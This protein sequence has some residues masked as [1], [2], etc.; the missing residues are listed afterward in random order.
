MTDI[1]NW[2][3]VTNWTG[4]LQVANTNSDGWFWVLILYGVFFVALLLMSAW[5]FEVALLTASFIGFVFGMFLAYIGLVGWAWVLVFV[6]L[7][8]IMI[9]YVVWTQDRS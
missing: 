1:A 8:L 7:I 6:G 5:G 2:T 3:N 4:I 9:L